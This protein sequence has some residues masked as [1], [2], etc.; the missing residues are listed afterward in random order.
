[1]QLMTPIEAGIGLATN[2][3]RKY[4]HMKRY[5]GKFEGCADHRL[6]E[7]LY[8]CVGDGW[9]CDEFGEVAYG[10]WHGL[11]YRPDRNISYVVHEDDQGF[12]DY[13]A[14]PS[15]TVQHEWA[16]FMAANQTD[17]E[18]DNVEAE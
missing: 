4:L 7:R 18:D 13:E 1:M 15:K 6:G 2:R 12:F 17:K 5:P 11:I 16:E 14:I 9:C 8:N 10:G 3:A